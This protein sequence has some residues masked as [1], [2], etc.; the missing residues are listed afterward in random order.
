MDAFKFDSDKPRLDLILPGIIEAIGWVRTYGV[1]KYGDADS[2]RKVEPWRY[3]AAMLRH[4][5]AY[6]R[7]PDSIDEE[8]GLPHLWHAACNIAFLIELRLGA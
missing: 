6:L 2:W 3:V 5:V 7:E 8:S 1:K 4:I